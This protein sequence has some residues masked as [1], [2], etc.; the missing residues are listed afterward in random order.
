VQ[1]GDNR[2]RFARADKLNSVRY[3]Y[4]GNS[5]LGFHVGFLENLTAMGLALLARKKGQRMQRRLACGF[6]SS[7]RL[8]LRFFLRDGVPGSLCLTQYTVRVP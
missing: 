1:T 6:G 2:G 4:E 7:A 5:S 3:S 8:V